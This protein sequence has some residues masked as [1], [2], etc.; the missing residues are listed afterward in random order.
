M[1][2]TLVAFVLVHVRVDDPPVAMVP[3]VA[4]KVTVGATAT[5][6]VTC[7]VDVPPGPVAV[8]V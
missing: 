3:G 4:V 1:I 6:T 5:V 7:A 2:E 8:I